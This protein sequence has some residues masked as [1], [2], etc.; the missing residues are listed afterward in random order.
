MWETQS[1][2]VAGVLIYA[3]P[4]HNGELAYF[5]NYIPRLEPALALI[6]RK[7]DP[8]MLPSDPPSMWSSAKRVTVRKP[9]AAPTSSL[10]TSSSWTWSCRPWT[11]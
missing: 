4:R 3:D 2:A 6:P 5:T 11:A 8:I 1:P 10:P 7:G 9:S